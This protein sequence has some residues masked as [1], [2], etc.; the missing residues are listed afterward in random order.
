MRRTVGACML[1][2]LLCIIN[3]SEANNNRNNNNKSTL[4]RSHSTV[5]TSVSFP[6]ATFKKKQNQKPK[7]QKSETR[8]EEFISGQRQLIH[9]GVYMYRSPWIIINNHNNEIQ[10]SEQ[11][12]ETPVFLVRKSG[13]ERIGYTTRQIQSK[14]NTTL[15]QGGVGYLHL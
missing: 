13:A 2:S 1:V 9:T 14:S 10:V 8:M 7:R 11:L 4:K 5:V 15:L 12:W 3:K 6:S